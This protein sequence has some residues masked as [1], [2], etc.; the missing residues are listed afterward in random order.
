MIYFDIECFIIYFLDNF[1]IIDIFIIKIGHKIN[2][3]TIGSWCIWN[4]SFKIWFKKTT[5]IILFD[6]INQS[7]LI[8][9]K[10]NYLYNFLVILKDSNLNS[11]ILR[12]LW[13]KRTAKYPISFK[14]LINIY[15]IRFRKIAM[16]RNLL[17]LGILLTFWYISIIKYNK[18]T[19]NLNVRV[20]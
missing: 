18:L 11:T 7:I 15:F 5:S 16:N 10:F 3:P 6:F 20:P 13:S 17:F 8:S 4:K 19:K 12:K 2:I 9:R 1:L 14:R